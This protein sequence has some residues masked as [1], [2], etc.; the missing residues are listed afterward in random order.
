MFGH[1]YILLNSIKIKS[2]F[3]LQQIYLKLKISEK[4]SYENYFIDLNSSKL[5]KIILFNLIVY[6]I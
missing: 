2:S 6:L 3:F 1:L 4:K 5:K